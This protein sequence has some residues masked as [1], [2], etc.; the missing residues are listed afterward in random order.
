M[1]DMIKTWIRKHKKGIII[2]CGIVA[3][4]GA[5]AVV[6]VDG[7]KMTIPV[8][9]FANKVVPEISMP[10]KSIETAGETLKEVTTQIAQTDEVDGASKF[11]LRMGHFRKLKEGQHAS[12]MKLA[13]ASAMGIELRNGETIVND[14]MVK[15]HVA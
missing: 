14:C 15:K 13:Q 11:F 10:E 2:T 8:K 9:E 6:I 3:T 7:K 12:A 5:V 1:C 4:V